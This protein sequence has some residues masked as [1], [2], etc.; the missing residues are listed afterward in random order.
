MLVFTRVGRKAQKVENNALEE[1]TGNTGI[2][3]NGTRCHVQS[4]KNPICFQAETILADERET[5]RMLY[6]R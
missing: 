2:E 6:L 3:L 5:F 4:M 1:F